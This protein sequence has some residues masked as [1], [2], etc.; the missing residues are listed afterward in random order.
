LA[1]TDPAN[2]YGTMLKWPEAPGRTPT[3]TAGAQVLFVNGA[4]AAYLSKGGRQLLVYLPEEE[5]QRTAIG[6]P[7][8]ARLAAIARDGGLLIDEINGLPAADHP[9]APFLVAA[10]FH[11]SAMGFMVRR[12]L[13][14]SVA[15][16][17]EAEVE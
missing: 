5:P 14:R 10:G 11:P 17:P 15:P 16:K 1:V 8:A 2:P 3:R 7:L 13:S 4:L 9:L 6:R 12:P